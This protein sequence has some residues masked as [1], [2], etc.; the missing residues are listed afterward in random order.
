MAR[1]DLA[2]AF[3]GPAEANIQFFHGHTFSGNPLGA[4]VGIAVLDELVEKQ[5]AGHAYQMGIYLEQ[6][7]E[8]LKRYGVVREV[9]GK[10]LFR[11]VEFV[12]DP[13]T[14]RPFP[15]GRKLGDAL[16]QTAI[17]NGLILRINSDWFSVAPPLIVDEDSLDE[18]CDLIEKSL[19]QALDRVVRQP[20]ANHRR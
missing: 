16:R 18:M 5:L 14:N 20:S 11:G 6:R 2:E 17:Q 9:R 12:E 3:L 7:L 13:V 8:G 4:A 15:V 10:G 1:Q 19:E